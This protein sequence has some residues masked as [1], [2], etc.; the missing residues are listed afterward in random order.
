MSKEDA[1]VQIAEIRRQLWL[2]HA[3]LM[4]GSGF[5]RNA[6][7][8]TPATQLPP[9]WAQLSSAF[10]SKLYCSLEGSDKNKIIQRKNVLQLAQEFE[11][12]FQRP[13][14]NALLKDLIQ[15]DNLLP[16]SMYVDMLELPWADIFTTN[17]DTLLER[18]A[19]LVI[20]KKYDIVLDCHDLPYSE[21]PRIIKLH[22]SFPSEATH[23]IVTEEDYRTY[24]DKYSP[25]VNSVQQAIMES[26]LCLVGFSGTDPNFLKWIGWVKDNLKDSMPPIYLIGLLNLPATERKVLESK[27]IIPIDLSELDGIKANEH[28][29]AL[30]KFFSLLSEKPSYV[31]WTPQFAS[32]M[33]S[34][35]EDITDEKIINLI[36]DWEQDCNSYPH[37]IVL[38]W[39]KRSSLVTMTERWTSSLEYLKKLPS[40]WD[41]KG[42]L[43]LNWRMEKCLMPIWN[44][45]IPDYE[46]I[47]NRYDPFCLSDNA[48]SINQ[49]ADFKSWWTELCFSL[50]RWSREELDTARWTRYEGIL[51]SIVGA[52]VYAQNRLFCEQIAYAM[53]MPCLSKIDEILKQWDAIEH[54]LIWKLKF[55]SVL[56]EIGETDKAIGVLTEALNELRPYIPKSKIKD[57]YYLLSLEGCILVSL[58]MAEQHKSWDAGG[59]NGDNQREKYRTR[60]KELE[61]YDC[62]PWE[63][64]D[65]FQ[66]SL[67]VPENIEPTECKTRNFNT[68]TRTTSYRNGWAPEQTRAFQLL[69]FFEETGIP[70]HVGN[71]NIANEALVGA[72]SRVAAYSPWWAFYIFNQIGK[73]KGASC[74][75]FY[76]Q[77]KLY[78]I[79]TAKVNQLVENYISQIEFIIAH[80]KQLLAR[81]ENNFYMR[82][83]KN[84]FE[85][86]SRLTVKASV[87]NLQKIFDLG[88]L[89]YNS[90]LSDKN[91][92]FEN[93]G[94]SY[95]SR[96]FDAMSPENI[97]SNLNTLLSVKIPRSGQSRMFWQPPVRLD[98]R[99]YK[100]TPCSCSPALIETINHLIQDLDTTDISCRSDVM[101]Y[102]NTCWSVNILSPAQ[103]KMIAN[104]LVKHAQPGELPSDVK[105]YKFAYKEFLSPLKGKYDVIQALKRYYL[106]FEFKFFSEKDGQIAISLGYEPEIVKMARSLLPTSSVFNKKSA[107]YIELLPDEC[108]AI[109][110]HF[111]ASW[112]NAKIVITEKFASGNWAN[113]EVRNQLSNS[114]TWCDK[115][116]GE[117]I[118]PRITDSKKLAEI[119]S[120]TND[121]NSVFCFPVTQIALTVHKKEYSDSLV[122]DIVSVLASSDLVKFEAYSYALYNAYRFARKKLLPL[123][124]PQMLYTLINAIGMKSDSTLKSACG[125]LGSILGYYKASDSEKKFLLRFLEELINETSFDGQTTRFPLAE[126]YDYRQAAAYLSAE[127]YKTYK[128]A[129]SEIPDVLRQ[130]H[131]ICHSTDEFPLLRNTWTRV[132]NHAE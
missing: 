36:T 21:A 94:S 25:F 42:L 114:L 2:G 81:L 47:L 118:T 70:L 50:L 85:A 51:K 89:I 14:L 128:N 69:R 6:D 33:F 127:F 108:W 76:S 37:W 24:P 8:T 19:R 109:F 87:D 63:N 40:P 90:D 112:N 43:E 82:L 1:L 48:S 34:P 68:V 62:N 93:I 11:V 44:N 38:P 52:D 3:S 119:E 9:D 64:L 54:P 110:E 120:L 57:D 23:L 97:F 15:D 100:S 121:I 98:W 74:E 113:Q 72:I 88:I 7:R 16:G 35:S 107:T 27:K 39:H 67:S 83:A 4:V 5:S 106:D 132:M 41:I 12:A 111:K 80:K 31:D 123:P 104:N 102:L 79:D 73:V 18:A 60:L 22:G 58:C 122:Y 46:E 103:K 71:V 10:A 65:K 30:E 129:K 77:E 124:P 59:K 117:V 96:L 131:D 101:L 61:Q 13:A 55:A 66:L 92:V 105:F 95:F 26:A 75:L 84:L 49:S 99:G 86:I 126:R 116:L 32:D 130:W 78:H 91:M 20:N 28:G 17:Y 115:I 125:I 29:R 53:A 45:I 56:T